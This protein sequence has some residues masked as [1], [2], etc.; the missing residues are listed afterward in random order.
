MKI[1]TLDAQPIAGPLFSQEKNVQVE[2]SQSPPPP[3]DTVSVRRPPRE[4]D[5][6]EAR[7]VLGRTMN[8]IRDNASSEPM[9]VHG[10]FDPVRVAALLA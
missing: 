3:S 1:S 7:M 9:V 6:E 10:G 2:A 8:M 5:D 4:L